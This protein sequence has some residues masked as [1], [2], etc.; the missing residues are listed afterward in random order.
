MDI[1]YFLRLRFTIDAFNPKLL[2]EVTS[3]RYKDCSQ[4]AAYW[5]G[6]G[7]FLCFGSCSNMIWG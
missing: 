6:L 2:V 4:V 5:S 1:V 3:V 7:L